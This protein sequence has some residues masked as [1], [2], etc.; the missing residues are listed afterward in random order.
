[1]ITGVDVLR[2]AIDALSAPKPAADG[3]ADPRSPSNRRAHGLGRRVGRVP[4][5]RDRAE[6]RRGETAHR[7]LPALGPRQR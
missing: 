6:P 1:M 3:T 2:T 7:D 5:R 4:G